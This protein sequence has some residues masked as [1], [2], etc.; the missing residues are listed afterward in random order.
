MRENVQESIV[1]APIF[2]GVF[3]AFMAFSLLVP[4]ESEA[5]EK[6][7]AAPDQKEE[8]DQIPQKIFDADKDQ[9]WEGL[10]EV[11]RSHGLPV[12]SADKTSG[13][14][15]TKTKRYFKIFSA[16]FPPVEKD[17]RDTYTINIAP[18]DKSTRVK[19][20][21]KFE[22]FDTNVGNW[23]EGDPQKE[24]AGVSVETLF[25]GLSQRFKSPQP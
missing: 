16:R 6:Q 10:L 3:L 24:E 5:Q 15:K 7:A 8:I 23:V 4:L 22:L 12:A 2:R 11:L 18:T 14:I 13:T 17:Y 20:E 25:N 9:V 19:I 1:R 21:R